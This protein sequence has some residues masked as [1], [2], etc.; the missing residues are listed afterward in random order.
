MINKE[1]GYRGAPIKSRVDPKLPAIEM[2]KRLAEQELTYDKIVEDIAD[3][4]NTSP[5]WKQW[6]DR[7]AEV[8]LSVKDYLD[9]ICTTE[10]NVL[11]RL[12]CDLNIDPYNSSATEPEFGEDTIRAKLADAWLNSEFVNAGMGN[13]GSDIPVRG[14]IEDD[15]RGHLLKAD[16]QGQRNAFTISQTGQGNFF[17]PYNYINLTVQDPVSEPISRNVFLGRTF[18]IRG[19][20]VAIPQVSF[21][22]VKTTAVGELG[23]IPVVDL[24][25]SETQEP[26]WKYGIGFQR[27]YESDQVMGSLQMRTGLFNMIGRQRNRDFMVDAFSMLVREKVN[28]GVVSGKRNKTGGTYEIPEGD[29]SGKWTLAKFLNY[30]KRW[31]GDF[32]PNLIVGT[33][34][35]ITNLEMMAWTE[36]GNSVITLAEFANNYPGATTVPRP[37]RNVGA[38]LYVDI[39][40]IT[41]ADGKALGDAEYL[42]YQV[43]LG[44]FGVTNNSLV[45]SE[46]ERKMGI[47]ANVDYRTFSGRALPFI[48]EASELVTLG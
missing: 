28:V 34:Q 45:V 19:T 41:K 10:R 26:L 38:L 37:V 18:N 44:M 47:Q 25:T 13:A 42:I 33:P 5:D 32:T 35:G 36:A 16:D 29:A 9:S 43:G 30:M 48:R 7:A 12:M 27:S 21:E 22:D 39:E 1:T 17:N 8:G 6:G 20:H 15:G 46:T 24:A 40:G 11:Y 2:Q 14:V 23:Q 3:K 4:D 31:N